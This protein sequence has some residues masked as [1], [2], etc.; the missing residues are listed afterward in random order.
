MNYLTTALHHFDRAFPNAE[1]VP[2]KPAEIDRLEALLPEPY[3]LPAAYCELL[4][5][6][7]HKLGNL[8]RH[9]DFS[10]RQ[11][12]FLLETGYGDIRSCIAGWEDEDEDEDPELPDN[13]FVIN[14]W[15]GSSFT[16][17]RLD[18]G[19][20]PSVY[21]WSEE[22]EGGLEVATAQYDRFSDFLTAR[23]G[24]LAAQ[25]AGLHGFATR[26]CQRPEVPCDG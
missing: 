19:D 4:A 23:V 11:V 22:N 24:K 20:D 17:M 21:L 6:G 13:L 7:G 25:E 18:E 12:K 3:R 5:Y 16:F 8:F 14:E 9:L 10:Y 2:C 26:I 15:L 1:V